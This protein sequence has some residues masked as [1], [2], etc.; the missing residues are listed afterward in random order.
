[1]VPVDKMDAMDIEDV[2]KASVGDIVASL[3]LGW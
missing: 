3:K 1:M 2:K